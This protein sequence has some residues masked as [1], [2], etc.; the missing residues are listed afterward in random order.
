MN[1]DRLA[2]LLRLTADTDADAET[3][4]ILTNQLRARLLEL[5]VDSVVPVTEGDA[6]VGTRS[7]DLFVL[8]S[9]LVTL[10]KSPEILKAVTGVLQSWLGARPARSVELHIAGKA[11]KVSGIGSEVQQR[12]LQ[13]FVDRRSS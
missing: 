10:G 12:L 1:D 7:G 13:L 8:G 5:D 11:L 9:L 6:P 3:V 4:D 2:L